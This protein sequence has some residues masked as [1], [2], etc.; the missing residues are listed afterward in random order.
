MKRSK[1]QKIRNQRIG[2]K[3]IIGRSE[4]QIQRIREDNQNKRI[5]IDK[6]GIF[7]DQCGARVHDKVTDM[8]QNKENQMRVVK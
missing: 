6:R 5:K 4:D 8:T 7:R 3:M 1:D 2:I